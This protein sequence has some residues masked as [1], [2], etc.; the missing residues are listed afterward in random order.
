MVDADGRSGFH[1]C[2]FFIAAGFPGASATT[3][4]LELADREFNPSNNRFRSG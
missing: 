4:S 2:S 3:G 1:E